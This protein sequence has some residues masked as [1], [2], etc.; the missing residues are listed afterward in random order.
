MG[1]DSE[2]DKVVTLSD[3]DTND[4][5]LV[6]KVIQGKR[7]STATAADPSNKKRSLLE[8]LNALTASEFNDICENSKLLRDYLDRRVSYAVVVSLVYDLGIKA[9][10]D[11]GV[12]GHHSWDSRDLSDTCNSTASVLKGDKDFQLP[13]SLDINLPRGYEV[14]LQSAPETIKR[15]FACSKQRSN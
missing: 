1:E 12:T 10:L 7:H 15:I 5:P 4:N 8:E 13:Q 3:S 2:T 6:T 11:A 9:P 14:A